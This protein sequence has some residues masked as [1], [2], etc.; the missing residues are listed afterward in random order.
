MALRDTVLPTGGGSDGTAP[1]FAPAGTMFD[2]CFATLHRDKGIWGQDAD[3]FRPER[4]SGQWRPSSSE[5]VPFGAGPRQCLAQQKATMEASYV[6]VRL[7]Q[8][9]KKIES[10]DERPWQA[11]VALTAK[12]ANGCLVGLTGSPAV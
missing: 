4:W 6:I 1:I 9:F 12:N 11:Q 10:R 7:L 8:E 5:F 2:T 3:V